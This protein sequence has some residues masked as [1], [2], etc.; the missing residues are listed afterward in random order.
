MLAGRFLMILPVLAIGGAMAGKKVAPPSLGT[1]PTHGAL[2]T[3]LLVFVIV[4]VGA[5]TFFPALCLGPI[6]EHFVVSAGVTFD[7][8][9]VSGVGLASP[10]DVFAAIT[11]V[12]GGDYDGAVADVDEVAA[13]VKSFDRR[14]WQREQLFREECS[15]VAS[16]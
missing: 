15:L 1:F 6:A 9:V 13:F 5:L 2:F 11:S 4:I 12:S 14:G 3:A 16:G 10:E 7:G 8:V